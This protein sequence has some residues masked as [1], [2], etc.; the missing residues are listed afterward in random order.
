MICPNGQKSQ[1]FFVPM[2]ICPNNT[3][4]H[5]TFFP[6][7]FPLQI[8]TSSNPVVGVRLFLGKKPFFLFFLMTFILNVIFFNSAGILV[9]CISYMGKS[10][11]KQ[12]HLLPCVLN[13]LFSPV[14]TNLGWARNLT[15][16]TWQFSKD[17][18]WLSCYFWSTSFKEFLG[19]N[20]HFCFLTAI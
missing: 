20:L 6:K 14:C 7:L 16:E 5:K 9:S 2:V 13:F 12:P 3:L 4:S 17:L 15:W 10:T 19:G 11:E 1:I 18:L 8:V